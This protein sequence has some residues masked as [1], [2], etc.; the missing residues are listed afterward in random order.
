MY[1]CLS[2]FEMLNN[3]EI[4]VCEADI[5]ATLSA[6]VTK[7]LTGRPGYVSDPVIDTSSD[8]IIYSHCVACTNVY[9][10][11][12]A[13]RSKYYLRSHAEDKLGASVQVIFPTG[14]KLTTTLFDYPNNRVCIHSAV[15]VGNMSGDEGCR[16][17][18][19]ATTESEK[20]L[21]GWMPRWHR[22]TVFGDYRKLFMQ[23]FKVK[24]IEVIEEDK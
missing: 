11:K 4:A 12:N 23:L 21:Y 10:C 15:A 2:H 20:L 17:K 1:P 13:T 8:Q 22:V 7:Y 18:L 14:D 24:G 16:S 19:A 9:G 5:N 6:V 3:D